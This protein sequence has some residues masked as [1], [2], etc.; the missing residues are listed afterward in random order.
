[1]FQAL[2]DELNE[3]EPLPEGELYD[4]TVYPGTD[5][6]EGRF[7]K[8]GALVPRFFQGVSRCNGLQVSNCT[9]Y[10]GTYTAWR[11]A[12]INQHLPP[13]HN[14]YFRWLHEEHK[15]ELMQIPRLK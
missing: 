6:L 8:H 13:L 5:V 3:T 14:T 11:E 4:R 10:R 2:T 1:M 15:A 7:A 12:G 9:T